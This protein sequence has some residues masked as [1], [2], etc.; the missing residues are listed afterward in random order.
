M[1][2]TTILT[3]VIAAATL[4]ACGGGSTTT[5]SGATSPTPAPA[6]APAP[7]P[8]PTPV[9]TAG[10]KTASYLDINFLQDING[11]LPYTATYS[12][13]GVGVVGNLIFGKTP[14]TVNMTPASDG[15]IAYSSPVVAGV[16]IGSNSADSNLPAIAMICEAPA[17]TGTN[18]TNN[19]KSSDVL[20]ASTSL[21]ITTAAALAGQQFRFYREDCLQGGTFPPTTTA[22]SIVFDASGNAT[23]VFA[24]GTRSF[25]AAQMDSILG[26]TPTTEQIDASTTAF[27]VF[28]AFSY[29]KQDG[30]TSYSLVEHGAPAVSGFTRAYVGVWTQQ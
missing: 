30:S 11:S 7:A 6:P 23:V 1:K 26:G 25:T 10:A 4:T 19:Q 21:R 2:F 5:P 12:D 17:T 29:K 27:V 18:G 20:V 16:A 14:V 22:Q 24:S 8:T 15:G 9:P 13:N 3:T 28:Y